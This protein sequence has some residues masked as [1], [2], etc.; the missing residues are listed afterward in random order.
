MMPLL[1]VITVLIVLESQSALE[2]I[3]FFDILTMQCHSAPPLSKRST[4]QLLTL[5]SYTE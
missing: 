1:Y 4:W 2:A 5:L 3:R